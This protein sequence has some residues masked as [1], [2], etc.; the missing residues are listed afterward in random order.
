MLGINDKN[1]TGTLQFFNKKIIIDLLSK[2][3][4]SIV[5]QKS[6]TPKINFETLRILKKRYNWNNIQFIKKI[7]TT[8]LLSKL[9]GPVKRT[10]HYSYYSI[11]CVRSD[12][13]SI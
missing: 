1:P 11:L 12:K 3:G 13:E 4:L 6:S 10:L 2:N 7:F 9:L 8:L 5:N